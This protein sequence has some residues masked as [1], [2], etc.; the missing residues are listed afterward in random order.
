MKKQTTSNTTFWV[1][2][3]VSTLLLLF[4]CFAT[5]AQ[6]CYFTTSYEIIDIASNGDGT[7]DYTI[8]LCAE[9][10]ENAIVHT[11]EYSVMYDSNGDGDTESVVTYNFTPGIQIPNGN[12]CLSSSAPAQTFTITTPCGND[13]TL[14][15]SGTNSTTN[16]EC[17]NMIEDVILETI[18]E[19]NPFDFVEIQAEEELKSE[20]INKGSNRVIPTS[21]ARTIKTYVLYPSLAQNVINLELPT[22]Y[23]EQ[24][25]MMVTDLNGQVLTQ[26]LLEAGNTKTEIN[27]TGL[28]PGYYFVVPADGSLG[29][30]AKSFVKL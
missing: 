24:V 1:R 12:Y 19:P 17:M 8:D 28:N 18:D 23:E 27:V 30:L 16:E 14:V 25:N 26:F 11:I 4:C 3:N 20:S 5:N 7:C 13:I 15:V 6:D 2:I 21:F 9:V 22:A 29:L 10:D